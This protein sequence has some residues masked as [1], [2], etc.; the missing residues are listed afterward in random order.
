MSN[1]AMF[2]APSD[3]LHA[4]RTRLTKRLHALDAEHGEAAQDGTLYRQLV[5]LRER[6][7][8]VLDTRHAR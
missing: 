5:A 7:S 2:Y 6:V 3:E 4:L 8:A 1:D